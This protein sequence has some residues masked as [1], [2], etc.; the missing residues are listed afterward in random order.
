MRRHELS[1]GPWALISDLMPPA[2]LRGGGR[3]R[4]HRQ[5]VNGLFWKLV[6]SAQ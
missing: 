4:D 2:L 3:W 1:P 5:V 6:T